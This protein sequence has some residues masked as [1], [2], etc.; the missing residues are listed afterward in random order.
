VVEHGP[1]AVV[2]GA[3]QHEHTKLFVRRLL[4]PF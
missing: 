4:H 2:L 3:P 1:P